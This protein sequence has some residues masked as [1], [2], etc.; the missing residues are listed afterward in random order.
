MNDTLSIGEVPRSTTRPVHQTTRYQLAFIDLDDTL[1]GP[2]KTISAANLAALARLREAGVQIAVASGRHHKNILSLEEIGAPG[3]ILSSH[4]SV[5]RHE[6]TDEILLEM[7]M[8]PALVAEVCTRGRDAGMSIIAYHRKGIFI[9]ESS[10][11]IDLYVRQA[12]WTPPC[13][14]FRALSPDGFQKILWSEEPERIRA[15]EPVLKSAFAGRLNVLGTNP[16]LLEFFAP[17]ANKA[18]GAQ[19]LIRKLGIASEETLAFGDGSN[20]VELLAWAGC[21]VAMAHGR[22]SAHRAARFTSPP[23]DP[24]S[25][26]ARAVDLAL[27]T[28]REGMPA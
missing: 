6:P 25:A 14:D 1:L 20:D 22:E 17:H 21:S 12:G 13:T 18:V 4:G 3:W 9:E 11:W 7:T 23:G 8:E 10:P 2:D 27:A 28:G 15:L 24:A 16:E 26:F 19:T 5:V